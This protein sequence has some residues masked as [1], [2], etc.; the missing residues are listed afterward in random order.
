[1]PPSADGSAQSKIRP[2]LSSPP[3]KNLSL[4]LIYSRSRRCLSFDAMFI[5]N[6]IIKRQWFAADYSSLTTR[7]RRM[8]EKPMEPEIGGS[9]SPQEAALVSEVAC[10]VKHSGKLFY[11]AQNATFCRLMV[12]YTKK[13]SISCRCR[14]WSQMIACCVF[15]HLKWVFIK[16]ILHLYMPN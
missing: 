2:K 9:I 8:S 14:Y 15:C 7:T 5:Y 13:M 1:M 11:N 6:A 10:C 16:K 12:F 3:K 4:T